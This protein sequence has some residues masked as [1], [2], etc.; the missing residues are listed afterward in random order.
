M[1]L[2]RPELA[3]DNVKNL[4]AKG[5]ILFEMEDLLDLED[6]DLMLDY[7]NY[8]TEHSRRVPNRDLYKIYKGVCELLGVKPRI[9]YTGN[10]VLEFEEFESMDLSLSEAE[11]SL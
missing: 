6:Q 9:V 3:R 7:I 11:P 1:K 8:K 4:S 5:R 2:D 10:N